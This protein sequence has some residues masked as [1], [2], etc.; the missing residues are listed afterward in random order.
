VHA[1]LAGDDPPGRA[2]MVQLADDDGSVD[3]FERQSGGVMSSSV[4]TAR[5]FLRVLRGRGCHKDTDE[6]ES[7]GYVSLVSAH[8]GQ[9]L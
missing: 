9:R 6:I 2:L 8:R 1:I 3:L 4:D 7:V 5:C